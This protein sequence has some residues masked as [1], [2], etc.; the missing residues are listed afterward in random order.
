MSFTSAK[1]RLY[2][3][4]LERLND[5]SFGVEFS[6]NFMFRFWQ[7][8]QG[9][10]DFEIM[11][12]EVDEEGNPTDLMYKVK[13]V[14][15]VVDVQSIEIPFVERNRR[16]DFEKEYYVAIRVEYGINEFNQRIIE[17][18][19]Q[20]VKY[21]ALLESLAT[22]GEN[23]LFEKD[24]FKYAFKVKEPSDVNIFKYNG[25]YYQLLAVGFTLTSIKKG[26]FG[27]ET[28][29]YFGLASDNNFGPTLDYQLDFTEMQVM[30]SKETTVLAPVDEKEH[31][32][33]INKRHWSSQ[34]TINYIGNI[35][36]NLLKQEV[37]GLVTDN[38]EKYQI[39]FKRGDGSKSTDYDYTREVYVTNANIIY[40]TNA[41][42]NLTFEVERV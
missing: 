30:V 23:L 22:I 18:D 10:N 34:I 15:P 29:V 42:V 26:Y 20:D 16:S 40:A 25:D 24:G 1:K 13:E 5:N 11:Y 8:G 31:K 28:Q 2:D 27:N 35:G 12:K 33:H 17:F 41:V 14:V 4:F 6:G 38:R 37:H 21:Q 39:R 32:V 19:E 36:D 9:I 7:Q 3:I